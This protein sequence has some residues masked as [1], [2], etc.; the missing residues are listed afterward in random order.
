[1]QSRL[2]LKHLSGS[3]ANTVDRIALPAEREITFGRDR[4]CHVCYN[5]ADDLVSR[6]HLK[7]VATNEQ[8]VRYMVVDLG[9][10]NGTFVNRQRV[11]G[12]VVLLPGGRVQLGPG[13]PEFEFQ[14]DAEER[15]MPQPA[16]GANRENS[17]I[18]G[19][20]RAHMRRLSGGALIILALAGAGAAG[21]AARARVAQLWLE[22]TGY[23][24]ARVTPLWRN[25]GLYAATR[26]APL[27]RNWRNPHAP[28]DKPKFT[29]AAALASVANIEMEW[30]VFD[31]Q[32]GAPLALAYIANER[33]SQ[34]ERVPLV[35]G[36][37]AALPA[38]VVGSDRRIEP[39]LIPAG[40]PH[41]GQAVRG[42]WTSKGVLVSETGAVLTAAPDQRPW[43]AP[44]RWTAEEPAGALLV[45]DSLKITQVVP[46]AAAQFP[47]W[48]P[49]ESGFFAEQAPENLQN[50]V[51]GR[52]VSRSDLR[53]EA[54]AGITASGRMLKAKPAAESS[55]IWLVAIEPS[56]PLTG[57]RAMSL[58]HRITLPRK[59]EPI[60]VVG[61]AVE[62][63]EI[64]DAPQEDLIAL[65]VS[66]RG[67][68]GVVF[69]HDGQVLALC[70]PDAHSNTG[71][72]VAVPIRRGLGLL[73]GSIDDQHWLP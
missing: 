56:A 54:T 23:A 21:Y 45:L 48:T 28:P 60:W 57:V 63:G 59:G 20:S 53:V 16:A 9:S 66:R 32:T 1:M 11:F 36:A 6:K 34:S 69:D 42:K 10:R 40:A 7:I 19:A 31:K 73:N 25:A 64:Q 4:E 72:A 8:P 22:A 70:V 58:D 51:R 35:E 68:G 24:V 38:F 44:W 39:L 52:R 71:A 49:A 12:A 47:R 15:R 26:I 29:A 27:W 43:N 67:E 61:D 33:V 2:V 17:K 14:L 46:L 62:A 41:A 5:A 37:P 13:G 50:D 30:N 55:G 65:R 3:R 18:E